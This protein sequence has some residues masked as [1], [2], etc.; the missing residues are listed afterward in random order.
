MSNLKERVYDTLKPAIVC[1]DFNVIPYMGSISVQIDYEKKNV[2]FLEEIL[3]KQ[4]EKENN[5]PRLSMKVRDKFVRENHLGGIVVTGD[6]AGLARST[7]T[8]DGTNNFTIIMNNMR[9]TTLRPQL[10]LL[11]KQPPLVTRLEFVN[12]VF[13]GFDGWNI[14]I[15]IRCRRLTE[16]LVNQKK[17]SDG[18]KNKPKVTDPKTNT[19]YEKYGHLSDCFDYVLCY[20]LSNSWSKFQMGGGGIGIETVD[21]PVYNQFDF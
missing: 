2:Y 8:E 11:S 9:N 13:N 16:D 10:R 14:Y 3:G 21:T 4:E 6:P 1:F 19:K 15:D 17:N 5:T 20:F 18:T 12:A 7:Q